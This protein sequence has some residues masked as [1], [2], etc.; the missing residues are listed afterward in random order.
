L[1]GEDRAVYERAMS[2]G[3]ARAY[4]HHATEDLGEQRQEKSEENY[5][6]FETLFFL[7][8]PNSAVFL[9]IYTILNNSFSVYPSE[10]GR[11]RGSGRNRDAPKEKNV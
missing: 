10:F 4:P 1:G 8:K 11:I 6:F 7:R 9:E 2:D 5:V 3:T